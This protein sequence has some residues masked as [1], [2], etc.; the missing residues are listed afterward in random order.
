MNSTRSDENLELETKTKNNSVMPSVVNNTNS[1][2]N[3]RSTMDELIEAEE[4]DMRVN[5]EA[6][7][8]VPNLDEVSRD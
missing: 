4:D 8:V 1:S 6:I 7:D 3:N 2:D 5:F